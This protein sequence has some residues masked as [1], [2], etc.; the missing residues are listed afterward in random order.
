M[1][2]LQWKCARRMVLCAICVKWLEPLSLTTI[3]HRCWH[4]GAKFGRK[5]FHMRMNS[6]IFNVARICM[7]AFVITQVSHTLYTFQRL[8]KCLFA[9]WTFEFY[10]FSLVTA[11]ILSAT[12]NW[13]KETVWNG[14][15]AA[16]WWSQV[17][18]S[19]KTQRC[20]AAPILSQRLTLRPSVTLWP[21]GRTMLIILPWK[22]LH[23]EK[24]HTS[25]QRQRLKLGRKS[26]LEKKL[27]S[28]KTGSAKIVTWLMWFLMN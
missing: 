14:Q 10:I 5:I 26:G 16:W 25:L 28:M 22:Q 21:I 2:K 6:S 13:W 19:R 23:L 9:S 7:T 11:P 24:V 4:V 17:S 3:L 18:S 27:N 8:Y 20:R 15:S 1:F 12:S